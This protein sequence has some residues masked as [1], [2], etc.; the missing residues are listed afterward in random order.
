[1]QAYNYIYEVV[2]K[3]AAILLNF[4]LIVEFFMAARKYVSKALSAVRKVKG[5]VKRIAK[6]LH[7]SSAIKRNK[8]TI[9]K[10]VRKLSRKV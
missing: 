2:V 1:M 7:A 3:Y 8:S 5:P 6:A 10:V 9:K 4:S